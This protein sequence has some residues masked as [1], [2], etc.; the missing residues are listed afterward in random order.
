MKPNPLLFFALVLRPTAAIIV[1]SASILAFGAYV[2]MKAPAEF[3][4]T[5]GLALVFQMFAVAAGFTEGSRRGY[6]DPMLTRPSRRISVALAHATVSAL[7][8]A[9]TWV[10]L[11]GI[12]TVA[13]PG[14]WSVAFTSGGAAVLLYVSAITWTF[15][16]GLPRY[17][18]GMLWI[19]LLFVL[20]A[21]HYVQPLEAAFLGDTSTWRGVLGSAGAALACPLF[22]VAHPGV[23]HGRVVF[24]VLAAAVVAL[25]AGTLRIG[26]LDVRLSE[27]S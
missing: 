18:G 3:G 26:I 13:H 4:Q 15:S 5:F 11:G 2:A 24:T 27:P 21:R 1:A 17:T 8:G 19:F 7:P 12:D 16:L 6:F 9:L 10:L 14:H 20:A 22:L 25:L 23:V